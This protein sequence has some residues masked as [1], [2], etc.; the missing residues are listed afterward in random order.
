MN[1]EVYCG[2]RNNYDS[3]GN[4]IMFHLKEILGRDFV[5]KFYITHRYNIHRRGLPCKFQLYPPSQ[6]IFS[7]KYDE[8]G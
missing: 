8:Y 6:F 2:G 5:S 7:T 4:L 3:K 1:H